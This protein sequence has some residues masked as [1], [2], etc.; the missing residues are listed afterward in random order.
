[1]EVTTNV[2]P[3]ASGTVVDA[4]TNKPINGAS[5]SVNDHPGIFVQTN[6]DGQF[7]LAPTTRKTTIFWLAPYK[8]PLASGTI[9]VS[10][11][12]YASREMPID[13]S[14]RLLL[15]ALARIR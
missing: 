13:S 14:A 8:T 5:I 12:G 4:V 2:T 10:A 15:V 9:V 1:M 11:D 6:P 7:S 3:S